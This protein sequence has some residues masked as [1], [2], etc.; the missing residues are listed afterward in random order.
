MDY[1]DISREE[2]MAFGD[3]DNDLDMLAFVNTGIAMGNGSE[4]VKKIAEYITDPVDNDG[5]F[6][7]VKR[8]GLI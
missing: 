1:F 3:G 5:I 8:Y 7:A 6:N 2:T 4:N